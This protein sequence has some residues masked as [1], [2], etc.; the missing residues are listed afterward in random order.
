MMVMRVQKTTK[1]AF[2]HSPNFFKFIHMPF[3]NPSLVHNNAKAQRSR[4][5][6]SCL[7]LFPLYL[8]LEQWSEIY[9]K[10][11]LYR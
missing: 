10:E 11:L 8:F 1:K 2:Y 7:F 9:V 5:S 3:I 6:E 4:T